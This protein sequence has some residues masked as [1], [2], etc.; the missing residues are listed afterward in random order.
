ME[1]VVTVRVSATEFALATLFTIL[2]DVEIEVDPS[3]TAG[4][5]TA[6][7]AV[8]IH[9][10]DRSTLDDAFAVDSSVDHAS[11][12]SHQGEEEE[13]HAYWV[14]WNDD[15]HRVLDTL[16]SGDGEI[17]AISGQQ[18]QWRFRLLYPC[19]ENLLEAYEHWTEQGL[20]VDI[21]R[22]RGA[23]SQPSIDAGSTEI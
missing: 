4:D 3:M 8:R 7:P 5:G 18:S 1:T 10:G 2:P 15:V 21:E 19:R 22:I 9:G 17:L 16:T 12:F 20:T 6:T 23:E 11:S 14:D 13:A